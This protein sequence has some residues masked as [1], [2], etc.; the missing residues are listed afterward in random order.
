MKSVANHT[1]ENK[2]FYERLHN[3]EQ[4]GEKYSEKGIQYDP[5]DLPKN[6]LLRFCLF[7]RMKC[8]LISVYYTDISL[9]SEFVPISMF[10]DAIIR[11]KKMPNKI[12]FIMTS[13]ENADYSIRHANLLV[14]N[15]ITKRIE[16]FD[17]LGCE[18]MDRYKTHKILQDTIIYDIIQN[19]NMKYYPE[20]IY[21]GVQQ[22]DRMID[23]KREGN[24]FCVIWSCLVAKLCV[25]F[26]YKT[27]RQIVNEITESQQ[28][29]SA[30]ICRGFLDEMRDG[31]VEMM[32]KIDKKFSKQYF[33]FR[34][35]P[36]SGKAKSNYEL[37][38]ALTMEYLA[39]TSDS[40]LKMT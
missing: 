9:P 30:N 4:K 2:L 10:K 33:E 37:S 27:L 15:K 26:P 8:P 40:H 12:I 24:G 21:K 11:A 34:N 38:K 13:L 39:S 31:A 14:Y 36:I 29:C 18:Y 3:L 35:V 22:Y 28:H 17:P 1:R 7:A 23:I 6:S 19:T 5:H 20:N 25:E 32:Q 16:V